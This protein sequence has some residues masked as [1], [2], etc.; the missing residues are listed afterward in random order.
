MV[1][2]TITITMMIINRVV[3]VSSYVKQAQVTRR[4]DEVELCFDH[5]HELVP[6][7]HLFYSLFWL[8]LNIKFIHFAKFYK[9]LQ[10]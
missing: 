4:R 7:V 8:V 10:S 6:V 1:I 9:R 5:D 2:I 3:V